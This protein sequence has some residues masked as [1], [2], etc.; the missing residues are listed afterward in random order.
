MCKQFETCERRLIGK[1]SVWMA[2]TLA[3]LGLTVCSPARG[4]ARTAA[5]TR[6][7]PL[8][9]MR[10]P[11]ATQGTAAHRGTVQ[12]VVFWD[13]RRVA[14]SPS[15][16]CQGLQV[17]L[18]AVSGTSAQAIGS[19]SQLQLKPPSQPASSVYQ[20]G[21]SF[22]G[23]PEGVTLQVQLTISAPFASQVGSVGPFKGT[24]AFEIPGGTCSNPSPAPDFESG[25]RSCGENLTNVN[26][27]LVPRSMAQA[28]PAPSAVLQ[29]TPRTL[30]PAQPQGSAGTAA[31]NHGLLLPAV[32]G[33]P[34]M[35]TPAAQRTPG[36]TSTIGN[37]NAPSGS[38]GANTRMLNPQP[39]PPKSTPNPSGGASSPVPAQMPAAGAKLIVP[40]NLRVFT[41]GEAR[42]P[43][44]AAVLTPA[45]AGGVGEI[46]AGHTMSATGNGGG[47]TTSR[48]VVQESTTATGMMQP[49][50]GIA[51]IARVSP[52]ASKVCM[53]TSIAGV[54]NSRSTQFT[55]GTEYVIRG[56]GFGSTPGKVYLSAPFPAHNGRL[57]LAP[58][59]QVDMKRSQTAYWSDNVI[60]VQLETLSGEPDE[61]KV[62]LVVETSNGQQIQMS[63]VSF[64]AQ[65]V[66]VMVKSTP[67]G[68][69]W[70]VGGAGTVGTGVSP[71]DAWV[72]TNCSLEVLRN[73]YGNKQTS[74]DTYTVTL[75]P[76]FVLSRAVLL[77][78]SDIGPFN[79]AAPQVNGNQVTVNW[80]WTTDKQTGFT[81]SMYGLQI[82]VVGPAGVT[83]PW[84]KQ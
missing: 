31:P 23:V 83:D 48:P 71:C 60:D 12:G 29:Q 22:S 24:T 49:K 37:S 67:L 35:S 30:L 13:S 55:P 75:K 25:W 34:V 54:N 51:G 19:T 1:G 57:D 82:F 68:S 14:Y 36:G 64:K 27:Q 73:Y 72:T 18:T 84:V 38:S 33:G 77:V 2:C 20:C 8:Q 17:N 62:V 69:S 7:A 78:M 46:G 43:A 81:Y 45:S 76:G 80:G 10:A 3:A 21:F 39:Y 32:N 56:C 58:Y 42:N 66:E 4:Q 26:F 9:T 61:N 59:W 41:I 28:T 47:P 79:Y 5:T 50:S 74:P 52:N 53:G 11:A 70:Q 16:S 6:R 44:A 65:R 63:N 40:Q 15:S